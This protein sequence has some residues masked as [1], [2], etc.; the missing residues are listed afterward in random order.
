MNA[1][2]HKTVE[3]VCPVCR[4]SKSF[5]LRQETCGS[6]C[7]KGLR[8]MRQSAGKLAEMKADPAKVIGIDA[9]RREVAAERSLRRK[10][11]VEAERNKELQSLIASVRGSIVH[12]PSWGAWKRVAAG[13]KPSIATAFFSD[14]HFD[15]VVIP[16]QVDGLNAYNRTI[17]TGRLREFF[18]NT[19]ALAADYT[20][21]LEYEA[22]C[23]PWGGDTFSGDIHDELAQTNEAT[24]LESVLYWR[25]HMISG[26]EALAGVFPRVLIP[27]VVG[28][29]PRMSRKPRAKHRPQ[30]NFDWLFAHLVADKIKDRSWGKR[31]EWAISDSADQQ[32]SL[33]GTRFNLTHGDQFRGG[34]GIAA[35]LSPLLLGSHRKSKRSVQANRPYDWMICGHWHTLILGIY[36]II[37]NGTP[38]GYDEY[39]FQGNFAY[40]PP[41]QA[42]W[43]T[44]PK[45]GVTIRAP[46]H[47]KSDKED[48]GAVP[49]VVWGDKA[50]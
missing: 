30:T 28:N 15:E 41:Q 47:C 10:I 9:A 29:H 2:Q 27:V 26:I 7:A 21:G 13:K 20:A 11:A 19:A 45:Y 17:A 33:Y 1:S 50:A 8:D 6:T 48:W 5:P 25:D 22:V 23:M 38:K 40:E 34:S 49:K 12:K 37:C 3:R 42:F 4:E 32:Y 43:V 35:A 39:A 24:I 16:E 14:P 46:I 18:Q 44:D 36:G 31:V